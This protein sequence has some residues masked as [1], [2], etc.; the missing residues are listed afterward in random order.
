MNIEKYNKL[1]NEIMKRLESNEITTESAKAINNLAFDKYIVENT[2]LKSI[3]FKFFNKNWSVPVEDHIQFKKDDTTGKI[4]L[5]DKFVKNS[6]EIS[7][8]SEMRICSE[9]VKGIYP[10]IKIESYNDFKKLQIKKV[11]LTYVKPFDSN[12]DKKDAKIYVG[13]CGEWDVDPEHG[14]SILFN[15]TSLIAVAGHSDI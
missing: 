11:V 1:H 12:P 9:A 15:G 10:P 2:E 13:I 14:F 5:L 7:K 8:K 4:E 3:N 6:D